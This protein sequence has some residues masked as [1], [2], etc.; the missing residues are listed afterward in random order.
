MSGANAA[1]GEAALML[2][3][4]ALVVRPSFAALVAA[5]AEIGSLLALVERAGD[6]RLTLAEMAAL[7]WHC[8]AAQPD[9]WSREHFCEAL[10]ASGVT[11]V[12][13]AVRMILRQL[14]TGGQ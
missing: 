11:N 1:R 5:E 8:V 10:L 3:G 9:G 12:M 14:V 2:E 4:L 13:P 7:T 6:G